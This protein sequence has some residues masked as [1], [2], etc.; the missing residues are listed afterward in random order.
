MTTG[1]FLFLLGSWTAVL[2]LMG[3]SFWRVLRA[4]KR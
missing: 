2:G 4:K 1:A 3:W